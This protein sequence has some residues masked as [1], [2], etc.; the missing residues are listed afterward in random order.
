MVEGRL[1]H[2]ELQHQMAEGAWALKRKFQQARV[3]MP[4]LGRLALGSLPPRL[5]H[6]SS[7]GKGSLGQVSGW[8]HRLCHKDVP[9]G[10]EA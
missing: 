7:A 5:Q 10:V 6:C 3:Q 9:G 2:C 1:L 8:G 4:V